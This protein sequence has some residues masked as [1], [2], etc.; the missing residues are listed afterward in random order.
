MKKL[1]RPKDCMESSFNACTS[2]IL[3]K[4]ARAKYEECLPELLREEATY[5]GYAESSRLFSIDPFV[6]TIE[7]E[8]RS[9]IGQLTKKELTNL[10]SYHMVKRNPGRNIYSRIMAT[11]N[12]ECPYCGGIGK[13]KNLDHYLPKDH[14][15]SFSVLPVNLIPSCR[16]CNMGE[17][18]SKFPTQESEQILHPYIEKDHFFSTQWIFGSLESTNPHSMVFYPSPPEDWSETDQ[19]RALKHFEDFGLENKYS[20]E[21]GREFSTLVPQCEAAIPV[22]GKT[23]FQQ[24]V[25]E[26]V[27]YSDQIPINHWKRVMYLALCE[28]GVF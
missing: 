26:P 11:A 25:L 28:N 3:P 12:D 2:S 18:G 8:E 4:N 20:V 14:F 24:C 23:S 19:L 5:E 6:E 17:K 13:P 27:A 21:A 22:I 15:P 10:Y 9:V 1:N 7:V 16:D